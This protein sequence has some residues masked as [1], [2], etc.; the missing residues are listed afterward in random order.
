MRRFGLKEKRR[1]K[2][3]SEGFVRMT[4]QTRAENA[5]NWLHTSR[6]AVL[7]K[8]AGLSNSEQKRFFAVVAVVLFFAATLLIYA[9][10]IVAIA[11]IGLS[12]WGAVRTIVKKVERRTESF[13]K[14]YPIFLLSLASSV[15]TGL[16]PLVA[17]TSCAG[18]FPAESVLRREIE[19]FQS[20]LNSGKGEE[21]AIRQ[22]C[23]SIQHDDVALLRVALLIARQ[24]G[25]SIANCLQRLAKVTRQRQSFHRKVKAAL[26]MQRLSAF[27]IA[28]S[29]LCIGV[30]QAI[31]NLDGLAMSVAD[32]TGQ[33][34][35]SA[36]G[37]LVVVG[38][39][40]MLQLSK[41]RV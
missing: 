39:I 15:R 36:G 1:L 16:D 41:A 30:L 12:V 7:L 19:K 38:V 6:F 2:I 5:K 18:L 25:A 35:L 24:Q 4:P 37:F 23:S 27:G 11:A 31:T 33:L 9:H 3:L 14:E 28:V 29:A 34:L 26:A 32:P 21:A 8:D 40:W 10:F 13:D 17:F 22:F 20:D